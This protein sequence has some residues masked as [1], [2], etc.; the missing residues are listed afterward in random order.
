ML[1]QAFEKYQQGVSNLPKTLPIAEWEIKVN[2][3]LKEFQVNAGI[4]EP[5]LTVA[6]LFI[7][8]LNGTIADTLSPA[9]PNGLNLTYLSRDPSGSRFP[10]Y[11]N[12]M[13]ILTNKIVDSVTREL[14]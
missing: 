3:L 2:K 6:N 7:A 13:D 4:K 12:Q 10:G 5:H 14:F 9:L 1:E 8:R 11:L